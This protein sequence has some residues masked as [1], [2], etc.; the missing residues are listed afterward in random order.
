MN[1][2]QAESDL[3]RV[4]WDDDFHR[5]TAGEYYEDDHRVVDLATLY[6]VIY[7]SRMLIAGILAGFIALGIVATLLMTPKYTA[8]TLVRIDQEAQKVLG[9]EQSEA[10]ASIQDADRFLKTEVQMIS[11]RSTLTGVARE[12]RLFDGMSF[13]EA[14]NEEDEIELTP[15]MSPEDARREAVLKVLQENLNTEL[16]PDSRVVRVTFTSPD[17]I[18]SARVAN[19]TA[20]KFIEMNLSRKYD[21]SAYARDFLQER[22]VEAQSRLA[23]AERKAV[24]YARQTRIIDLSGA[25]TRGG[26]QRDA[27]VTIKASVLADLNEEAA[28]ATAERILAEERWQ[29]LRGKQMLEQPEVIENEAIQSLLVERAALAAKLEDETEARRDEFPAVR[30]LRA[31]V[32]EL[33]RQINTIGRGISNG[34]RAEYE[35]ALQRERSLNTKV[36]DLKRQSFDEQRQ[37]IQLSILRR[38]ADT[39]RSQFEYL[40]RRTNEL[41]AE[42]GV[43][44][45]NIS[46]VDAA[47]VPVEP[48]SPRLLINLLLAIIA[49]LG[50]AAVVVFMRENL[51]NVIISPEDAEEVTGLPVLGAIPNDQDDNIGERIIDPKT[52]LFEAY[53]AVRTALSLTSSSGFPRTLMVTS[54]EMSEGK[55]A[56]V[57][58]LAVGLGRSG[59]RVLVAD[60]DLRRPNMHNYLGFENNAGLS[61]ALTGNL[62]S[63]QAIRQTEHQGVSFIPAGPP[64]PNPSE[65]LETQLKDWLASTKDKY[66]V[67]LLDCPPVLGLSDAL[68]V[69]AASDGAL[70][71]IESG[72]NLP[73]AI[74]WATNRLQK[75]SVKIFGLVISKFDAGKSGLSY[76]YSYSYDYGA[77]E[78][79]APTQ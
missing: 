28:K 60:A 31:Q 43:Q 21:N 38:E 72:R 3:A 54:T 34:I 53:N 7:R 32:A 57:F 24:E 37:S 58:A 48:S 26:Q 70:Y 65:L 62:S 10:S 33:D 66:D 68:M 5:A 51:F 75:A 6:S 67:V 2:N 64:P 36:E 1:S 4:A 23:D 22:L 17:P 40:L 77:D 47:S 25:T 78:R 15:F 69:G 13:L 14:M 76:S 73:K 27:V 35:I 12:L 19:S 46:L 49:G 50:C 29:S 63:D 8:E 44:T 74:R 41:N 59:R 61:E 55:S 79:T 56:T 18:L 9:T 42:A 71:V 52:E 30:R 16:P 39:L 45:N 11:S 20:S